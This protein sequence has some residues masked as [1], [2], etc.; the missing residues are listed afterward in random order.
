MSGAII[1]I[2]AKLAIAAFMGGAIYLAAKKATAKL[3]ITTQQPMVAP[4]GC[5]KKEQ[6]EEKVERISEEEKAPVADLPKRAGVFQLIA[7][8]P[9]PYVPR[10][11]K[12]T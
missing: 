7:Y 10:T 3:D 4:G 9:S 6:I 1:S 2:F 8:G 11:G 12:S 5:S